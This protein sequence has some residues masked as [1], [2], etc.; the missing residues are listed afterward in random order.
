MKRMGALAVH[1]GKEYLAHAVRGLAGACDEI[2]VFYAKEPSFG[3]AAD[4]PC[5]D[6]E[7]E[8]VAEANRYAKVTWHRVSARNEGQH[9]N[10]MLAEARSRDCQ[11]VAIADA[12]ELWDPYVLNQTFIA[13]EPAAAAGRPAAACCG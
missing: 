7:D 1:Y 8:L 3:F 11:L 5:P 12:D 4:R 13:V 6:T 10:A 2:H 9:R